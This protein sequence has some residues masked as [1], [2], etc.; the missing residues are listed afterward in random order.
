MNYVF[1]EFTNIL[2]RQNKYCKS[3]VN[4]RFNL[5]GFLIFFYDLNSFV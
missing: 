3:V 4:G 2:K 5:E 1:T